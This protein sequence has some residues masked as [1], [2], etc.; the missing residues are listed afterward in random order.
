MTRTVWAF[1]PDVAGRRRLLVRARLVLLAMSVVAVGVALGRFGLL[2]GLIAFAVALLIAMV[3]ESWGRSTPDAGTQ[4]LW[5]EADTLL[6]EGPDLYVRAADDDGFE[7][8]DHPPGA[9]IEAVEVAEI[10]WA[11]V[12]PSIT[13]L[14]DVRPT[15][16]PEFHL[17]LDLQLGDGERRCVVFNRRIPFRI[18]GEVALEE[19]AATLFGHRYR[20]PPIDDPFG[21]IDERRLSDWRV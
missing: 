16:P 10:A 8:Q 13:R 5:L 4:E 17:V 19:A 1:E 18:R 3:V 6:V 15:P 21:E 20:R 2:G 11:S 14:D 12:Y 7:R 9:I